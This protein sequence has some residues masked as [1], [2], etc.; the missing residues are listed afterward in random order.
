LVL[1]RV[2]IIVSRLLDSDPA[3]GGSLFNLMQCISALR[4]EVSTGMRHSQGSVLKHSQRVYGVTA[5]TK[6]VA[7]AQL[8]EL[9]E[10]FTGR[11]YG[12]G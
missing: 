6:V 5:R 11:K 1:R 2:R 9:Y 10:D 4:I 8:E 7:L 12:N 3:I